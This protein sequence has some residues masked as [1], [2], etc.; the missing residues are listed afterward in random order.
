[1]FVFSSVS[2]DCLYIY[3]WLSLLQAWVHQHFRGIGS[4]DACGGYRDDQH[5]RAMLF[6]PWVGLSTLDSYRG[7]LDAL[8]LS[9][10][11]MTPYG[12]HRQTCPFERVSL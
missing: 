8:N 5:P 9:G 2:F 10:V 1:M 12:E 11:V 4:K 6:A 3:M 7:H